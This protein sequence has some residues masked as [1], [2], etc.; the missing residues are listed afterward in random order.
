[1]SLVGGVPTSVCAGTATAGAHHG[2]ILQGVFRVGGRR[3]R[4]L[5][6]LPCPLFR[7]EAT[8]VLDP[9]R[10]AV[11]VTPEWKVKA[12]TAARLALDAIGLAHVG[13][14]I[15][16]DSAIPVR[17][18]F[19][20][21]T[22][23][24]V[25]TVR[26]IMTA[27]DSPFGDEELG[28]LAV[29]SEIASDP[30]MFDRALLFAQRQGIVLED[31]PGPLP[32]LEVLGFSTSVD[33]SGVPTLELRPALYSAVEEE[34]FERLRLRLRAAV[35]GADVSAVGAV[36]SASARLNQRHLPIALLEALERGVEEVGGVGLQAA[37][38][39]DIAG[40]LFDPSDESLDDRLEEA[41]AFLAGLGIAETWRFRSG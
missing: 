22:S 21:S 34:E 33:G 11:E 14:E 31:F 12:Q 32:E 24:I 18:G 23:D 4:G 37:H 19:G 30:L 9:D 38:S 36:A 2:E 28:A 41:R 17:R 16:I 27:A 20:S 7:T 26:A 13:A 35:A 25:A 5:V 8:V 39:G 3:V 6:T 29:R 15:A 40:F 1:V 10:S